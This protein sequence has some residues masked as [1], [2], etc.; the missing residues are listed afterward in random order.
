V[1]FAKCVAAIEKRIFEELGAS[2]AV[3]IV[4]TGLFRNEVV[5]ALVGRA[6]I[7]ISRELWERFKVGKPFALF[8]GHPYVSIDGSWISLG[9]YLVNGTKGVLIIPEGTVEALLLLR[10]L[11][12]GAARSVSIV[13]LPALCQGGPEAEVDFTAV[14][15]GARGVAPELAIVHEREID[16]VRE[17]INAI[18]SLSPETLAPT[19]FR[20]AAETVEG[21]AERTGLPKHAIAGSLLAALIARES[22]IHAPTPAIASALPGLTERGVEALLDNH[23][24]I[25]ETE[26][27]RA[28]DKLTETAKKVVEYFDDARFEVVLDEVATKWG[29]TVSGFREFVTQLTKL[30]TPQK[31]LRGRFKRARSGIEDLVLIHFSPYAAYLCTRQFP[32]TRRED[33][34][35]RVVTPFGNAE[36]VEHPAEGLIL[37][38]LRDVARRH[39]GLVVLRGPRGVGKSTVARVALYKALRS[40]F[41]MEKSGRAEVFRPVV[42]EVDLHNAS[43]L[44][45]RQIV[46]AANR[47]GL[48]PIFFLDPGPAHPWLVRKFIAMVEN[49]PGAVAFMVLDLD[50]YKAVKEYIEHAYVIDIEEALG[51][52][53]TTFTKELIER[54]SGCTGEI[55][56]E[57]TEIILSFIDNYAVAAVLVADW[58]KRSGCSGEEVERAIEEVRRDVRRLALNYIWH[59]VLGEDEYVARW[60]APLILAVGFYGPHPPKLGEAIT[61]AMSPIVEEI[62]GG[63]GSARRDDDALKWLSQP[64]HGTF[65]E[66]I[67]KVARGAVYKR[68]GV[69]GDEICQGSGEGPCRLVKI[70]SEV[71]ARVPLREYSGV[72]EVAEEY[73]KLVAKTLTTPGPAGVR[74]IDFLIDDFLH[75]YNGVAEEGRWRLKYEVEG[76]EGVKL[77]ENVVDELDIMAAL[78]GLAALPGWHP[79][80]KPLEKWFFVGSE[81][82]RVVG[83]YLYPLLRE[84][85]K[86][87]IKRA[88]AIVHEAERR[89]FYADVDVLRGVGIAAAGQWDGATDE[90]LEKAVKLAAFALNRFATFSLEL[91]SYLKSLLFEA[92]RRIVSRGAF[93]GGG[94]RQRLADMLTVVAYN[95][96]RGHPRG[97]IHFFVAFGLDK[98]DLETAAQRFATLYNAASN[99]GKLLLLDVLL[100]ALDWDI[101]GVNIAAALL[102]N[103]LLEQEGIFRE[104]VGR[105]E[106]LISHLHGIERAYVAAPLYPQLATQY[107]SFGELDKAVKYAEEA[108]KALE[109][110]WNAYEKDK[111]LTEEKL[112]PYLELRRI[113]PDLEKE[114]YELSQHVYYRVAHVYMYADELDKA[115]EYAEKACVLA[116]KLGYVYYEALSCG[117]LPRL[118]AVRS[119]AS[120]LDE[121]VELWQRAVQAIEWLGV[122]IIA[123]SLGRY[124]VALASVGRFSDMES[125]LEEWGW[126]LEL[127]HLASALTYGVLSL[128]DERYLERAMR[129][130]PEGA[131]ANLPRLADALHDAIGAGLFV[132]DPKIAMSAMETLTLVY[133]RDVVKTLLEVASDSVKLFLSTLVGLAYCKKGKE[134][135]LKLAK[136]TSRVGAQL[137][138]G[139]RGR[140]FGELAKVT[141]EL[142]IGG[143]I[144]DRVL[145]VIFKIYYS[146]V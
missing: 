31:E 140:L 137:F 122:V 98:L 103:P 47:L 65:Y 42:V 86:E 62:F 76:P 26:L 66:V 106:E 9:D 38:A 146:H 133:G 21:I 45:F 48:L 141:E 19:L 44:S 69:G 20:I 1:D 138:K 85:G 129:H 16:Y 94:R 111:A 83:L 120:P 109:E 119:G 18:R 41:L 118:K 7:I 61:V 142:T 8:A 82:V 144:T 24:E 50:Q 2:L 71:L 135:G 139:L 25:V 134:W 78:Y 80:L 17:A 125:A 90:E 130:L 136:E 53:K 5:K 131:G 77:V 126:A 64:L 35:L 49:L 112:R 88:T 110:L 96:A 67:E 3:V 36:Y 123:T 28:V 33:G 68:F 14:L 113:K 63:A 4:P 132:K 52:K 72:V 29:H 23:A 51:E 97:L 46:A 143:C 30:A 10:A 117:L 39:G 93:K 115:V 75:A 128:F 121:F 55:A 11:K 101:G 15:E 91:L 74:Q 100:Y 79:Q 34:K 81:K 60:T 58:L 124:V 13:F 87:L 32:Y 57:A 114:L 105:V 43:E 92:W 99:A 70:C 145:R 84:R 22:R 89:G 56:A 95:A 127:Y 107:I 27:P 73:A 116:K 12:E 108:L 6:D 59:V 102:G 40:L 104:V 54:Y 37:R